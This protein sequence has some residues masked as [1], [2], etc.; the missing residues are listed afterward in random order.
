[1]Q[2]IGDQSLNKNIIKILG[3]GVCVFVLIAYWAITHHNSNLNTQKNTEVLVAEI[4]KVT[5]LDIGTVIID[6]K[7]LK[8]SFVVSL[9]NPTSQD[10]S[11]DKISTSCGC[12]G[13]TVEE[14]SIGP[15]DTGKLNIKLSQSSRGRRLFV[16]TLTDAETEIK[17]VVR[18]QGLVIVE[19]SWEPSS[20]AF[21][22]LKPQQKKMGQAFFNINRAPGQNTSLKIEKSNDNSTD[23]KILSFDRVTQAD[24]DDA[25]IIEQYKLNIE[26]A[27]TEPGQFQSYIYVLDPDSDKK[28]EYL[29]RWS[30]PKPITV[31]PKQ[32]AFI[33]KNKQTRACYVRTTDGQ[34]LDQLK[35]NS[36]SPWF[37]IIEAVEINDKSQKLVLEFLPEQVKDDT[38]LEGSLVLVFG[39]LKQPDIVVP[40]KWYK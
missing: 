40:V 10:F 21:A 35:Y 4:G 3:G 7:S 22:E 38:Q 27:P 14:A 37:K 23:L 20:L 15:S 33:G 2:V 13:A 36:T 5:E 17:T 9:L 39:Q 11:V 26:I 34:K 32:I 28:Y 25:H 30:V 18:L 16:I 29:V 12:T 8:H 1:M 31:S 19:H 6:P 24:K